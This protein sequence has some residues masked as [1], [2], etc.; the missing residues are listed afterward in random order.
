[1]ELDSALPFPLGETLT[2]KNAAGTLI[3]NDKLGLIYKVP[4]Q[5]LSASLIR[6]ALQRNT[7][8]P[9]IV[10]ALRNESG[11]TLQPKRVVRVS[12]TAGYS[13]LEAVDGYTVTLGQKLAVFTDPFVTS[14]ADDD[15]FWGILSGPTIVKTAY[16]EA[17][18]NGQIAVG[19]QLVAATGSTSGNSQNGRVSNVTLPGQTGATLAFNMAANLLA[20]ALSA[21]TTGNTDA[22]LLVNACIR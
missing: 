15:I 1:M 20:V 6:T 21:R 10:V 11:L 18:F 3:N 13:A 14:I 22:D 2:G 16:V 9:L 19:A 8:R 5:D 7:Y 17:D 4:Y 12:L